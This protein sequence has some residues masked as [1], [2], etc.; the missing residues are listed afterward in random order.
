VWVACVLVM[1]L[2][3]DL[4]SGSEHERLPLATFTVWLW[5]LAATGYVL[6]GARRWVAPEFTAGVVI[7]WAGVVLTAAYAPVMVTG[8][9]PTEIPIAALLAPVFGALATGFLALHNANTFEEGAN[10][11]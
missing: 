8:T 9:D 2:A 7:V 3:P 4:V 5:G 11:D 10:H 6:S 1:L